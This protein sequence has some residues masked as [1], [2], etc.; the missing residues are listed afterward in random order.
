[1]S[2]IS[3]V[4]QRFIRAV[5]GRIESVSCL[6]APLFLASLGEVKLTLASSRAWR[7]ECWSHVLTLAMRGNPYASPFCNTSSRLECMMYALM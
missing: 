7:I 4:Q 6:A 5:S 2:I 3:V 1:V